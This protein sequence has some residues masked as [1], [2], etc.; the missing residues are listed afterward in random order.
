MP[1]IRQAFAAIDWYQQ[2]SNI[3]FVIDFFIRVLSGERFRKA[4][5]AERQSYTL[6][7]N[8][9]ALMTLCSP[10]LN[11][12]LVTGSN[13]KLWFAVMAALVP[14][15]FVS[16][17]LM[18]RLS[19]R[20]VAGLSAAVMLAAITFAI[21][22]SISV[23]S[24][25]TVVNAVIGLGLYFCVCTIGVVRKRQ[26]SSHSEQSAPVRCPHRAAPDPSSQNRQ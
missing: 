2:M 17:W 21:L 15:T 25:F 11:V 4:T 12:V 18:K 16:F 19:V 26:R 1:L 23:Y 6:G 8:L 3:G 10:L 14:S 20:F 22:D 13:I 24:G 7:V 5:P 9:V